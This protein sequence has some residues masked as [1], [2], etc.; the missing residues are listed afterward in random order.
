MFNPL[1]WRA[2]A[3]TLVS[4][5]TGIESA[6]IDPVAGVVL[7]EEP[8]MKRHDD[9]QLQAAHCH[10][11]YQMWPMNLVAQFFLDNKSS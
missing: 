4:A 6:V 2:L 10:L 8:G 3:N 11:Q 7:A 5:L 1:L 9:D